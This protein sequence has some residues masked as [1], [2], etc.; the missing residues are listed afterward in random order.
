MTIDLENLEYTSYQP[1]L[2]CPV[3]EEEPPLLAI[4]SV[5]EVADAAAA[6]AAANVTHRRREWR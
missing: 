6:A 1:L 2:S 5:S 4:F 3:S